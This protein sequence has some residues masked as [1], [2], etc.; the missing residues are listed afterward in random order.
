MGSE[1]L[2]Y[3]YGLVC[4]SMLAFNLIYSLY[5]RG[6]GRRTRR[7]KEHMAAGV[8]PALSGS[9]APGGGTGSQADM[10]PQA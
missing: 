5:L 8:V 4:L 6:A 7:R 1:V 9:R 10:L 2:I 3:G